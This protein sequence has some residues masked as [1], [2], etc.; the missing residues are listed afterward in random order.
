MNLDCYDGAEVEF[1]FPFRILEEGRPTRR[2]AGLLGTGILAVR[3]GIAELHPRYPLRFPPY[4]IPYWATPPKLDEIPNSTPVALRLSVEA[5]YY[6][7]HGAT[8]RISLPEVDLKDLPAFVYHIFDTP[9]GSEQPIP[10]D[11][12]AD[13]SM[14]DQFE[15]RIQSKYS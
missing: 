13:L 7:G 4:K 10:G 5:T 2:L 8:P 11:L 6:I 3:E 15:A 12:K 9:E 1:Y 14:R